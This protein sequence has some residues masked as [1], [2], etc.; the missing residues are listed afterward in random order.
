MFETSIIF[1]EDSLRRTLRSYFSYYHYSRLHLSLNKD[2]PDSGR[3]NRSAQSL[4]S[5]RSADCIIDTSASLDPFTLDAFEGGRRVRVDADKMQ[6]S[7]R[8]PALFLSG[9]LQHTS[10]HNL[11]YVTFA[12]PQRSRRFS[13][14][15]GCAS[16][17]RIP[18]VMSFD[19][20]S[21]LLACWRAVPLLSPS[22]RC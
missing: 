11:N 16:I 4:H 6:Q 22:I 14:G 13:V 1:D 9:M 21:Q 20:I 3:C 15:T 12:A 19:A 7:E 18:I 17:D 5:L 8:R 10:A 2:S